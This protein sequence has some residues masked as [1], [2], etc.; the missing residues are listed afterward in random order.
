MIMEREIQI[1][2]GMEISKAIMKNR[3]DRLVK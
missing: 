3:L 2:M 1:L